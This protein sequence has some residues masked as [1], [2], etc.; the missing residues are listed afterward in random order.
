MTIQMKAIEQYFPVVL[1]TMLCYYAMLLY[2]AL[3]FTVPLPSFKVVYCW[4]L[5]KKWANILCL[6]LKSLTLSAFH[7]FMMPSP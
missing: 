4:K 2:Y 7:L 3:F 1:F 5:M 6:L